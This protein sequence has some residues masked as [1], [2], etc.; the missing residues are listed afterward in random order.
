MNE[1]LRA[2]KDWKE[3]APNIWPVKTLQYITLI[4]TLFINIDVFMAG[5]V[6]N[7]PNF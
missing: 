7:R 2:D 6:N 3:I 4:L 5:R 1:R